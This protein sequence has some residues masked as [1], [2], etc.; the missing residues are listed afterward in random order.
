MKLA[1]MK[2]NRIYDLIMKMDEDEARMFVTMATLDLLWEDI[3][4]NR[5]IVEAH[6]RETISK[7]LDATRNVLHKQY[8]AKRAADE[9]VDDVVAQVQ[10]FEAIEKATKNQY[11]YGQQFDENNVRRNASGQFTIKPKKNIFGDKAIRG[12]QADLVGVPSDMAIPKAKRERMSDR[13]RARY[14]SDYAQIAQMMSM[15]PNE[16]VVIT[17]QTINGNPTRRVITDKAK[18]DIDPEETVESISVA[19]RELGAGAATFN[20]V[21]AL[22]GSASGAATAGLMVDELGNQMPG[23]EQA[24]NS[25]GTANTNERVYNRIAAGSK[26]VGQVAPTGSKAQMAAAFASY[27]GQHGPEAE[28]VIGPSARKAA[29]R[30][31]GTEKKPDEKLVQMFDRASEPAPELMRERLKGDTVKLERKWQLK[32]AKKRWPKA[33]PAEQRKISQSVAIPAEVRTALREEAVAA[34]RA[35]QWTTNAVSRSAARTELAAELLKGRRNRAGLLG[36][37][38]NSGHVPPSEGVIID[39]KGEIVSQ[40]IGYAD[41]HYLPFNLKNLKGL[42]GGEYVRTRSTGGITS[43]DIYTGLITGAQAVTVVSRSGV[44]T[45]E[46]EDDFKGTRRYNDKAKRMV[47]RYEK[48][49]DAV[50]SGQTAK[51]TP[52]PAEI[53]AQL[54][55]EVKGSME[56]MYAETDAERKQLLIARER[57]YRSSPTLTEADER[58]IA[59]RLVGIAQQDRSITAEKLGLIEQEIRSDWQ[60]EKE[61][62]FALNG[63]GYEA[64]L[65]A[66]QEQFPY[67]IKDV[68]RRPLPGKGPSQGTGVRDKAYV[69]P[70][71]NRPQGAKAGYFDET[72]NGTGK[73]SADSVDFQ[74][75]GVRGGRRTAAAQVEEKPNADGDTGAARGAGSADRAGN[76]KAKVAQREEADQRDRLAIAGWAAVQEFQGNV[77]QVQYEDGAKPPAVA[78]VTEEEFLRDVQVNG[79]NSTYLQQMEQMVKLNPDMGLVSAEKLSAIE[80]ARTGGGSFRSGE[81]KNFSDKTTRTFDK[82]PYQDGANPSLVRQELTKIGQLKTTDGR[83]TLESA[84]DDMLVDELKALATLHTQV[85]LK[86][87]NALFSD[88]EKMRSIKDALKRE[89][90]DIQNEIVSAAYRDPES[91]AK[92]AETVERVRR[93]RQVQKESGGV[94]LRPEP[95]KTTATAQAA[96]DAAADSKSG[97]SLRH[98]LQNAF[99]RAAGQDA[100]LISDALDALDQGVSED[101]VNTKEVQAALGRNLPPLTDQQRQKYGMRG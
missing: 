75:H 38:L 89:G 26:L 101:D 41:D 14:Q 94:E 96:A 90:L 27:A 76:A 17:S 95:K 72:I 97:N 99:D 45:V 23:F 68:T 31:R 44:Y 83:F 98:A 59:Q 85:T 64:A 2:G 73:V 91:L 51:A 49:L 82:P 28:K 86:K 52:I 57:D 77:A 67:Y 33:H 74:N 32:E 80:L 60:A 19:P 66:L 88:V 81:W 56:Y 87:S 35:E 29:Y 10:A 37:Q 55:D 92:R 79:R 8:I 42:K 20:L 93:L 58:G 46:F 25:A 53:K 40:A 54:H 18:I 62:N 47:D 34:L 63:R 4:K 15:F 12:K 78:K 24:W 5:E 30:Y 61:L 65:E 21:G 39:A 6:T 50:A 1:P 36:L 7:V 16:P 22:G 69:K 84:P 43:E 100:D 48:L 71:H 11:W 13:D 3:E 9:P 70:R